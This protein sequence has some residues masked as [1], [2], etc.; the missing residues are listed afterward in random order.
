ML[1]GDM[2]MERWS[3]L[4]EDSKTVET[5]V[6]LRDLGPVVKFKKRKKHPWKNVTFSKLVAFLNC[7]DGPKCRITPNSKP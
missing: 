4:H 6:A 5:C 7:T 1:S 2:E 3:E